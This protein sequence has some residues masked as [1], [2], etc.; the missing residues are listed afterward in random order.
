[1]S[2]FQVKVLKCIRP[3][4]LKDVVLGQYIANPEYD[5]WFLFFS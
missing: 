2:E 3:V 4:E 5:R 1:M